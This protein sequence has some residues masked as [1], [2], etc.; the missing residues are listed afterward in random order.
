MSNKP[1]II[2]MLVDDL[3][4]GDLSCFNP[5]SKIRTKNLDNL[6][7]QGMA[8][9]DMHACAAVCSPSRYGLMTGRYN[10]RSNTKFGVLPG[11]SPPLIEEGRET[12]ASLLKKQG[13]RTACVGKWHLGMNWTTR[14]GVTQTYDLFTRISPDWDMGIDFSEPAYGGPL[15][16]GFDY[17]YGLPASLS[18]APVLLMENRNVIDLPDHEDGVDNCDTKTPR[19]MYHYER[20]PLSPNFDFQQVVPRCD[21]KVLELVEAYSEMEEP[22]FIYYPTLAVHSPLVPAEEFKGKS[23]IGDY[24]DFVLQ[25]D[26]FVG[27]LMSKLEEKNLAENT[28]LI[29]TSDNG[30]A[31]IVDFPALAALGHNPSYRFRGNKSDIWEGGHRVPFLVRWPGRIKADSRC[32]QTVC[33]TDMLATFAELTGVTLEDDSGEDSI[34]NLSLWMGED[35]PVREYTVSHSVIGMYAIRKGQWKLELCAGSGSPSLPE[36]LAQERGLPPVQLYDLSIDLGEQD[37]VQAAH[38]EVVTE[39]KALLT[40][41]I[42]EGRST[43]GS[44]QKNNPSEVWPGLEWME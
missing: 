37:N 19:G 42:A 6:A 44:P 36:R 13:Y 25:I 21:E 22:F 31:P 7:S 14:D 28:I 16:R 12:I 33:L 8:C 18:Q 41:C 10:W 32:A 4:F 5:N 23:G 2:F 17:F 11:T 29:F 1:N 3:G 38:P 30:C 26:D 43:S 40:R 35:R 34:S 27:R 15:D 39:L 20:G 24:G 9:T